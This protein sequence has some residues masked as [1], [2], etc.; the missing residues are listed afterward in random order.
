MRII[1][2]TLDRWNRLYNNGDKTE[3]SKLINVSR[4]T[5]NR[6]FKGNAHPDVINKINMFYIERE[7]KITFK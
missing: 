5:I 6:A 7:N 2:S 4:S 1:K 3:L